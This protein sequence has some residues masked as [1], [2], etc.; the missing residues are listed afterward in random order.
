MKI[1]VKE[2]IS[3]TGIEKMREA[4]FDVEIGVDMT[5]EQLLETISEYDA[6]IVR[7]ATRV[8]KEVLEKGTNLKVIGRAGIGVDNIDVEEATKLGIIVA[9]APESNVV[10]A[11]EHTIALLLSL[12]RQIPQ[13]HHSLKHEKKWERS[14]FDGVEITEKVMGIIGLGRVGSIV[15]TKAKGLG[16]K[17]VAYDPYVTAERFKQLGVEKANSLHEMLKQV[18]F[19]SI[20]LPKTRETVGI[21]GDREFQIM[22]DG[23]YIVNTARGGIMPECILAKY[24][25]E[26]KVAGAALDVYDQEPCT[27][28]P[29]FEFENVIMTPHLGASTVEA[30]DKAGE[31][32][33]DQVIAALK[34]EFVSS[35]VNIPMVPA[36][37]MEELKN[38]LPLAEMVGGVSSQLMSDSLNVI[39]IN[40][41][42]SLAT[43][44][45]KLLTIAVLK[46]FFSKIVHEPVT[47]VNAPLLAKERGVEVKV[48]KTTSYSTQPAEIIV[49]VND[50]VVSGSCSP[51]LYEPRLTSVYGCQVDIAPSHYMLIA[52]NQDKPGIIGKVGTILG[53]NNIN[54]AAMQFGRKTARGKA[55]SVVNVDEPISNEVL[56]E[57]QKVDGVVEARFITL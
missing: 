38:F 24:L 36:E 30:Q 18:D 20:H 55:V 25:K 9:N 41:S 35:A 16:M 46:G 12:L 40:Y 13:A 14:K 51:P 19:L 57:I 1:L 3:K 22:K 48:V 11:A 31:M 28:S 17:V 43:L 47:Y 2:K 21:I 37:I 23:I 27:E 42:G 53:N 6:L 49:K 15:A 34:G 33:A 10:S 52:K 50:L 7:S 56:K 44:D 26:G 29:L 39:E 8:D 5:R 4:G 32:I 54:I 45:T